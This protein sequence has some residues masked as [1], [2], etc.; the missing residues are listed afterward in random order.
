MHI[1]VKY[2]GQ[3]KGE[4]MRLRDIMNTNVITVTPDTPIREAGELMQSNRIEH[5][6]VLAKNNLVG[7]VTK[8][9][10]L[11]SRPS[12]STTLSVW[13]MTTLVAK[14]KVKDIMVKNVI[15]ATP[16]M[17]VESAIALAQNKKIGCLPVMDG[18]KLVGIVTT[19]I[20]FLKILNPLLG[21]GEPGI[22]ITIHNIS[23]TKDKQDIYGI[24]TKNKANVITSIYMTHPGTGQKD[25][26]IHLD[27]EDA[28][29][30][31]TALK[32]HGYNVEIKERN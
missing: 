13:E 15:T 18:K 4:N 16:D 19:N 17:T 10:L 21:I 25:L 30:I 9:N 27:I 14:L 22:R 29:V 20:F 24:I 23:K 28:T 8:D 5:L 11:R 7:L 2:Y 1:K 6:P 3:I 31:V 12:K 26:T 32:T